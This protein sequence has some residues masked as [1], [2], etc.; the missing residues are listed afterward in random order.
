[1]T[2]GRVVVEPSHPYFSCPQRFG[3]WLPYPR[4]R[5]VAS[6][7]IPGRLHAHFPHISIGW[8][9]GWIS[10][11]LTGALVFCSVCQFVGAQHSSTPTVRP[12]CS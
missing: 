2:G 1:M 9:G 8:T 11:F 5:R 10:T 7:A 6:Q 3:G 4:G 12:P